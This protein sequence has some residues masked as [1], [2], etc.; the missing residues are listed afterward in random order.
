MKKQKLAVAFAALLAMVG[1]SSCLNGETDPTVSPQELM[2]VNGVAGYY[3]FTSSYGY[4]ITPTNM[5]ALSDLSLGQ[6]AIVQYSYDSSL[7]EWNENKDATINN[8]VSIKDDMVQA[9]APGSDA[10]NAPVYGISSSMAQPMYFDKYNLFL[11]MT[12]YYK[13]SS[14]SDVLKAELNSHSF[15]LYFDPSNPENTDKKLVLHLRHKVTDDTVKRDDYGTEYRHFNIT[16]AVASYAN[17]YG[18]SLPEKLVVE[19]E[20]SSSSSY[21]NKSSQT[22]EINYKAVFEQQSATQ[23]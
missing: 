22:L 16:P 12:Y 8:V 5:S 1:F 7:L 10:G 18:A 11:P 23:Q 17:L 15:V 3:T 13:N 14:D 19:Y 4:T 6:Y 2:K 21:E 9:T 20:R